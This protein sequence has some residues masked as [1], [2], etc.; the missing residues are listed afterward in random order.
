MILNGKDKGSVLML[1]IGLL[2]IIAMLG[3]S[4]LV[5]SYL[6]SKQ[7]EAWVSNSVAPT[8]SGGWLT[9]VKELLLKDKWV[10]ANSA[11]AE[12][13]TGPYGAY[14]GTSESWAR[15]ID[16]PSELVDA[17]LTEH[18]QWGVGKVAMRKNNPTGDFKPWLSLSLGTGGRIK[19]DAG[20]YK[21]ADTNGD[22]GF[23]DDPGDAY[24]Y[25]THLMDDHGSNYKVAVR[26]I[27]LSGLFCAGVHGHPEELLSPIKPVNVDLREFLGESIYETLHSFRCGKDEGG[28]S[29]V[30]LEKYSKHCAESLL[31][32]TV[33][34]ETSIDPG[35]GQ[36]TETNQTYKPFA[37]GDELAVRWLQPFAETRE[38]RLGK[39]IAGVEGKVAANLTTFACS[40]SIP[41]HPSRTSTDITGLTRELIKE[42]FTGDPNKTSLDEWAVQ[43]G[44]YIKLV[45]AMGPEGSGDGAAAKVTVDNPGQQFV[46]YPRIGAWVEEGY[47]TVDYTATTAYGGTYHHNGAYG[48]QLKMR[49]TPALTQSGDY[50]VFMWWPHDTDIGVSKPRD[51]AVGVEITHSNGTATKTVDQ[52]ISLGNDPEN[53]DAWYGLGTFSFD[54][55]G[56][57]YVDIISPR[58]AQTGTIAA[59]DAVKFVFQPSEHSKEAAHVVANMWAYMSNKGP[60]ESS[61]TFEPSGAG[62]KVYGVVEQL[63]ISEVVA[64]HKPATE[65][66][67]DEQWAYAIELFNPTDKDV[68]IANGGGGNYYRLKCGSNTF[69]F[70]DATS[71]VNG[72]NAVGPGEHVV[73][74]SIHNGP[75]AADELTAETCEFTGYDVGDI[76]ESFLASGVQIQRFFS[77][78]AAVPVDSVKVEEL[79]IETIEGPGGT[80]STA[81]TVFRTARRDDHYVAAAQRTAQSGKSMLEMEHGRFRALVPAYMKTPPG[82]TPGTTLDPTAYASTL[83]TEGSAANGWCGNGVTADDLT[84]TDPDPDV[85][86]GFWIRRL[87]TVPDSVGGFGDVYCVGPDSL[88]TDLPHKLLVWETGDSGGKTISL[89]KSY[90][91]KVSRGRMNLGKINLKPEFY[92]DVPWGTLIAEIIELIQPDIQA[93]IKVGTGSIYTRIYGRI[94]ICTGPKES[95]AALPYLIGTTEGEM[96]DADGN[97]IQTI[98]A[99]RDSGTDVAWDVATTIEVDP[100][101]IAE[102]IMAYRQPGRYSPDGK[103]EGSVGESLGE[104]NAEDHELT[105][106][107]DRSLWEGLDNQVGDG[108]ARLRASWGGE[109]DPAPEG[110]T[111][112][113]YT[114]P[115]WKHTAIDGFLT[116]G[117]L[118]IPLAK[119]AEDL[120]LKM[121]FG[122]PPHTAEQK[123]QLRRS[124]YFLPA[125]DSLYKAVANVVTVNSDTFAVNVEMQ[126]TGGRTRHY[127]AV[128]DRSN[129]RREPGTNDTVVPPVLLLLT[130]VK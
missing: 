12:K 56:T 23:V 76:M 28:G 123:K 30:T 130:E 32:A 106:Q 3:S 92:P 68:K 119:Y 38:S 127:V 112:V 71:P 26:I 63:V 65:G 57:Q 73:L 109:G 67:A 39:V 17:W 58:G 124:A 40:S 122:D 82:E 96:T 11:F 25:Q 42:T 33:L 4:L 100:Q 94:N 45:K 98:L 116:P 64:Y 36:P 86:E 90:A 85:Y 22:T 83:G 72:G 10:K 91:D 77:A 117:E 6:S 59:A 84:G 61:F 113:D 20:K 115:E 97:K 129:C 7:G 102:K 50:A 43:E 81:Q 101:A 46:Y 31:K 1:V 51:A 24:I 62:W 41:R 111:P 114:P 125:R 37:I 21:R 48:L 99:H 120:L 16:Y 87:G 19:D 69:A 121:E 128:V 54:D 74:Y 103:K 9:V 95:L 5:V 78:G 107:V 80:A 27:D 35:T 79:D 105:F 126:A 34:T 75:D 88:G 118:A 93:P 13:D 18:G 108:N 89:R 70:N 52:T 29:N 53:A 104:N 47:W 110:Q 66:L 60:M 49:Y 2:T 15:Y 55:S 8:T 44:L 14:V